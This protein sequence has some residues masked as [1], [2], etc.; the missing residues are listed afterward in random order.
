MERKEGERPA[1]IPGGAPK[2]EP[3]SWTRGRW[4]L[5]IGGAVLLLFGGGILLLGV[6]AQGS[7]EAPEAAKVLAVQEKM[8]FQ[9]LIPAYMPKAFRR[10]DVE[11]QVDG[12]GP[13][14]EPM[15]KLSYQSKS[16]V[17]LYFR[18]W[19]PVHPEREVLA[20]SRPVQ[21]K[22]GRGWLLKQ[23]NNLVALW[24]DVGPLRVS[25]YTPNPDVVPR[26]EILAMAETLGPA[27]NRQVFSFLLVRPEV[28]EIP[29]PPP[30]EATVNA[31][32]VQEIALVVTPGGYTPLRFAFRKDVPA[33]LTFRQLGQ[34][35][36][37]NELNFP[38]DSK[39]KVSLKLASEK[40]RKVYD[41]TPREAGN[42]EFYCAHIMFRGM[43]T[44]RK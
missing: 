39:Q 7:R 11:I 22:W 4:A 21:T 27:S 9:I 3:R 25:I 38:V 16:G 42:F 15:V 32:G 1:A 14:G 10:K 40:D 2:E 33:R 43:M 24:T 31:E 37:G 36:C 35:G 26:E 20:S 19:V 34:V 28:S 13:G 23:G 8:P 5:L 30:V 6:K 17:Q 29:P 12:Q 41:F 44:V 18:E